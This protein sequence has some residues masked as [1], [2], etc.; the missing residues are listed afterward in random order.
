MKTLTLFL[1]SKFILLGNNIIARYGKHMK[2]LFLGLFFHVFVQRPQK[3]PPLNPISSLLEHRVSLFT[4][5]SRPPQR[6]E[7]ILYH[8]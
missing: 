8:V 6:V 4:T 7:G 1:L 2:L 5:L 3:V